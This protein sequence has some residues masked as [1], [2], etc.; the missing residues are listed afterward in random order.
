MAV[1]FDFSEN[2]VPM[3]RGTWFIADI[4]TKWEAIEEIESDVIEE[5]HMDVINSMVGYHR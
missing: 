5:A 4:P 1:Y 2:A 3:R